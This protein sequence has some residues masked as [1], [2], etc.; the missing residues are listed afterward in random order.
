MPAASNTPHQAAPEVVERPQHPLQVGGRELGAGRPRVDPQHEALPNQREQPPAAEAHP[1]QAPVERDAD[2]RLLPVRVPAGCKRLLV[3]LRQ[4][5]DDLCA[6]A[7]QDPDHL[8]CQWQR[9][10]W[11]H[12]DTATN[13]PLTRRSICM[14]YRHKH[15]HIMLGTNNAMLRK[16]AG[17]F[18]AVP[19]GC[20]GS[21][22]AA[23]AP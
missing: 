4:A 10:R 3:A 14:R 2:D 7:L 15:R 20:S 5:R 19:V 16:I 13:A 1:R 21:D 9:W 8:T 12:F 22:G 17:R 6:G 23:S 11:P 18:G